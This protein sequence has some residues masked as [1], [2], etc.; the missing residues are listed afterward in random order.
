MSVSQIVIVVFFTLLGIGVMIVFLYRNKNLRMQH[1]D[2]LGQLQLAFE[3]HKK[4]L[5]TRQTHLNV[6]NFLTYNLEEALL[7]QPKIKL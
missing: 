4:Q 5:S 2:Q 7:V 6:Y 1:N 3:M